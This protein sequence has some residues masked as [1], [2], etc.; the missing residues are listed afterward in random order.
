[1]LFWQALNNLNIVNLFN[2]E[3]KDY[4][5]SDYPECFFGKSFFCIVIKF[6]LD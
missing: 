4:P 6:N 2:N 3:R 1:M 5:S